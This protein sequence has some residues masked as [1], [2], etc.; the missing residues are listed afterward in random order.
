MSASTLLSVLWSCS[1]FFKIVAGFS[2]HFS[3]SLTTLESTLCLTLEFSDLVPSSNLLSVVWNILLSYD[4][5]SRALV[6]SERS[7][8]TCSWQHE[9][10]SCAGC[11]CGTATSQL[12]SS[13]LCPAMSRRSTGCLQREQGTM[14]KMQ[15]PSQWFSKLATIPTK[16]RPSS[17]FQQ[18]AW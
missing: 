1:C 12:Q 7:H 11:A 14:W 17:A 10:S 16:S 13:T 4:R 2:A 6:T 8:G 18:C 15:F 3:P 5:F 9:P